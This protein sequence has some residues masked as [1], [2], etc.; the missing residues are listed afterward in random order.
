MMKRLM[1]PQA[2]GDHPSKLSVMLRKLFGCLNH[3][4]AELPELI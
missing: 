2:L 4:L 3:S 1:L